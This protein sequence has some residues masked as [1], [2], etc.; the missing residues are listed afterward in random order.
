[1]HGPPHG[2]PFPGQQGQMQ[3]LQHFDQRLRQQ[4]EQGNKNR[5]PQPRQKVEDAKGKVDEHMMDD[6]PIV[7]EGK[8]PKV[9][10]FNCGE[11][12]H[13]STDCREPKVCFIC[14]TTNHVGRDCP[15]WQK[16]ITTA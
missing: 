10:C 6:T 7:D 5:A 4:I 1:M 15:E 14:Q 8:S 16:P 13:F 3:Q 12:G 11:W 9:T 2:H